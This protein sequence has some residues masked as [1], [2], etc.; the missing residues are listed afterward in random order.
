MR[1]PLSGHGADP[2]ILSR[3]R[4][5]PP[6]ATEACSVRAEVVIGAAIKAAHVCGIIHAT[7]TQRVGDNV[8][9][10]LFL[11]LLLAWASTGQATKTYNCKM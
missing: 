10:L 7:L 5:E 1:N 11:F 9:S 8:L 4:C 6:N 2:G 3:L